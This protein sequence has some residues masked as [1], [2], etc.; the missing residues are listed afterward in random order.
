M[1]M[2]DIPILMS[3]YRNL[4]Y[5]GLMESDNRTYTNSKSDLSIKTIE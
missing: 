5:G 3:E 4:N 1:L 2:A